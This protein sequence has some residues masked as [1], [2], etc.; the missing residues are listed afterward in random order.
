MDRRRFMKM[1]AAG[2]TVIAGEMWI[3]GEKTIFLPSRGTQ[4]YD[5][6]AGRCLIT[7]RREGKSFVLLVTEALNRNREQI[8]RNVMAANRVLYQQLNEATIAAGRA[9]DLADAIDFP[10]STRSYTVRLDR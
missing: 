3:P 4:L 1:L 8:A 9:V 2:G 10:Y 7:A 5:D 6:A